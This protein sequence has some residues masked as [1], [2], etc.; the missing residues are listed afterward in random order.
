MI[1]HCI[2]A[3]SLTQKELAYRIY[4]TDALKVLSENT[5]RQF[6]GSCLNSRWYDIINTKEEKRSSD[7]IINQVKNAILK[8]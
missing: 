6:G 1:E 7:E 8:T 3:F 4:I 5:S 2:S